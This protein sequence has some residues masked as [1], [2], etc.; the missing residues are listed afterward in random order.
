[1]A[2]LTFNEVAEQAKAEGLELIRLSRGYKLGDDCAFTFKNLE[3]V[4]EHLETIKGINRVKEES[5]E[6]LAEVQI[7]ETVEEIEQPLLN[8]VEAPIIN[9]NPTSNI[10]WQTWQDCYQTAINKLTVKSEASQVPAFD[11]PVWI[12][13]IIF[14]FL[15]IL[16][17]ELKL[18]FLQIEKR[19]NTPQN[20]TEMY[21]AA[22]IVSGS[23]AFK[24]L[25]KLV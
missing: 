24:Q 7:L 10:Y 23:Q 16:F 15:D 19:L 4:I 14:S 5:I 20:F 13:L 25:Q 18:L 17:S 2:R 3:S 8:Q 22:K 12:G 11:N 1:M 9:Q 6:V 21:K